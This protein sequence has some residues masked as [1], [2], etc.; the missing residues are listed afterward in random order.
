MGRRIL[1]LPHVPNDIVSI[2][3]ALRAARAFDR[4]KVV[5]DDI[6]SWDE[7]A[8]ELAGQELS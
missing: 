4:R 1:Q 6:S 2:Q 3:E 5:T 7:I 8:Q